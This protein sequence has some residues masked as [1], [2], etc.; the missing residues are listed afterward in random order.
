MT[1]IGKLILTRGLP[2]CGKTTWALEQVAAAEPGAVVRVNRD[3]L[4]AML[5][6]PS[7]GTPIGRCEDRVSEVQRFAVVDALGRGLTVI[8]DDTNLQGRY[9]HQ[10]EIL[11]GHYGAAVVIQDFTGVPVDTCVARDLNRRRQGGRY[12]GEEVIRRMHDRMTQSA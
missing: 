10:W 2:G 6:G 4:R 5:F 12:V 7:Y 1:N 8:V 11:A 9:V 3:D